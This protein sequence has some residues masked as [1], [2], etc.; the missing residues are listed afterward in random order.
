MASLGSSSS[1]NNGSN[2]NRKQQT[3][4]TQI[5]RK[6]SGEG[7]KENELQKKQQIRRRRNKRLASFIKSQREEST[8]INTLVANI[9]NLYIAAAGERGIRINTINNNFNMKIL[10]AGEEGKKFLKYNGNIFF[11]NDLIRYNNNNNNNTSFGIVTNFIE[12]GEFHKIEVTKLLQKKETVWYNNNINNNELYIHVVNGKEEKVTILCDDYRQTL[13]WLPFDMTGYYTIRKCYEEHGGMIYDTVPGRLCHAKPS[14]KTPIP[15]ADI[16][17]GA[18]GFTQGII[19]GKSGGSNKRKYGVDYDNNSNIKFFPSIIVDDNL[20]ALATAQLNLDKMTMVENFKIGT[21]EKENNEI[22]KLI[23]KYI[24]CKYGGGLIVD[25]SP[26]QALSAANAKRKRNDDR[27]SLY[28]AGGKIGL[29]GDIYIKENSPEVLAPDENGNFFAQEL[30]QLFEQAGYQIGVFILSGPF[31]GIP[32]T[33]NRAFFLAIKSGRSFPTSIKN[34]HTVLERNGRK[35]K[36]SFLKMN[37]EFRANCNGSNEWNE[38]HPVDGTKQLLGPV[39]VYDKL[40]KYLDQPL[41]KNKYA[42]FVK[43]SH[44]ASTINAHADNNNNNDSQNVKRK[45]D[46]TL[47]KDYYAPTI[48]ASGPKSA[49]T[50]ETGGSMWHF[51]HN[52]TPTIREAA[53]LMGFED[54][55]NFCVSRKSNTVGTTAEFDA[56]WRMMGNA[57]IPPIAKAISSEILTSLHNDQNIEEELKEKLV[58]LRN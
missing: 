49:G 11:Q 6:S 17:C 36:P 42:H 48:L 54:D 28:I 50:G 13:Q 18:G 22:I 15:M 5:N 38:R 9:R 44:K 39:T 43:N 47:K 8:S 51:R 52:R 20:D 57:V 46:N 55:F 26:C 27:N 12:F 53:T 34:T 58:E 25:G 3:S 16:F 23:K 29:A 41:Q 19:G 37:K 4:L 30:G 45:Q 32:Q 33:R 14:F 24:S 21:T 40:V 1:N 2:S 56:Y 10:S 31:Y 35:W 7:E